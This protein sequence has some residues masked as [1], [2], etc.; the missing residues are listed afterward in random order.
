MKQLIAVAIITLA[1]ANANEITPPAKT[2]TA[3]H[4]P[5]TNHKDIQ[6]SKKKKLEK[7]E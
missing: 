5:A 3:P 2:T 4:E 6:L 1:L 7:E